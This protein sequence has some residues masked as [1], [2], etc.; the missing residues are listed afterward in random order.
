MVLG[1]QVYHFLRGINPSLLGIQNMWSAV[2]ETPCVENIKNIVKHQEHYFKRCMFLFFGVWNAIWQSLRLPRPLAMVNRLW[3]VM[4]NLLLVPK[5]LRRITWVFG[6]VPSRPLLW[7]GGFVCKVLKIARAVEFVW[8]SGWIK[9]HCWI[10]TVTINLG[11]W[12]IN[13]VNH[14]KRCWELKPHCVMFGC[15]GG[16]PRAIYY[17]YIT[18]VR[19]CEARFPGHKR[20]VFRDRFIALLLR[21]AAQHG[22]MPQRSIT[23]GNG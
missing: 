22:T 12:R 2:K 17:K 3:L 9:L 11:S 21:L 4:A 1:S 10:L 20:S 13:R 23:G 15:L 5:G 18:R 16:G 8:L 14:Q 6:Q 7:V 19:V